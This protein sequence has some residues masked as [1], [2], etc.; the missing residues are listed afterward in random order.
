M[1]ADSE[2][3]GVA[4]TQFLLTKACAEIEPLPCLW[5]S[6]LF[7][8]GLAALGPDVAPIAVSVPMQVPRH[9]SLLGSSVFL[10]A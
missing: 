5:H 8:A 6:G 10:R 9:P 4:Y 2:W 3:P 1:L 7:L